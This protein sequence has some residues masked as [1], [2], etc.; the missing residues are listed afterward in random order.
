MAL[1]IN[2]LTISSPDFEGHGRIPFDLTVDGRNAVPRLEFSGAPDGTVEYAIVCHDPDA[3]LPDG[4]THWTVY[5]VPV[6]A[7]SLDLSHPDVRQGP[8]D[9]GETSWFG[10]QPPHGHGA[11]HYY[12]WVYALRR[13][14]VGTPDRRSFITDY[15][16]AIIEQARTVGLSA[17]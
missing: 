13:P 12:F 14:V 6:E 17:R 2:R 15:A 9:A 11:H 8:N 7:T 10:P 5:G 1:Y 4:F 16:D 3:P